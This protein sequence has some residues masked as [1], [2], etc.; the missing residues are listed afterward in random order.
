[1]PPL[2]AP[3]IPRICGFAAAGSVPG[4][5]GCHPQTLQPTATPAAAQAGLDSATIRRLGCCKPRILADRC[6]TR[7]TPAWQSLRRG[8]MVRHGYTEM[9]QNF[10][11]TS[12]SH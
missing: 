8:L 3:S 4:Q 5:A 11:R 12:P 6:S 2:P 1:M 10:R 7:P 9:A